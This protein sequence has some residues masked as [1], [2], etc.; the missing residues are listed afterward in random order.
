MPQ[1]IAP[2]AAF[3]LHCGASVAASG[4]D[5]FKPLRDALDTRVEPIHAGRQTRVLTFKNAEPALDLAHA[6]AKPVHRNG[7]VAQML[8]NEPLGFG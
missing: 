8:Q 2:C 1:P 3:N 4:F 7:D 5:Q 6:V